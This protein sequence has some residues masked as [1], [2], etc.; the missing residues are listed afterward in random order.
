[1]SIRGGRQW[2]EHWHWLSLGYGQVRNMVYTDAYIYVYICYLCTSKER[3]TY[4]SIDRYGEG[5]SGSS[6][7]IGSLGAP[8]VGC[9]IP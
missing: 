9:K 4:R 6:I 5:V 1:M 7:G 3:A 2:L 8:V